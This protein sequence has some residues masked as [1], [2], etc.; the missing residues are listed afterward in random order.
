MMVT[1][2]NCP[3]GTALSRGVMR[4]LHRCS[5]R[6]PTLGCV[7]TI[8]RVRVVSVDLNVAAF[9]PGIDSSISWGVIKVSTIASLL[10]GVLG[11]YDCCWHLGWGGER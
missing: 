9:A 10:F 11:P 7:C 1:A 6:R 8:S 2:W 4:R 5:A 3:F